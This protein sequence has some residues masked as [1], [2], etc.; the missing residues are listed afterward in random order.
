METEIILTDDDK[1]YASR[2]GLSHNDMRDF[3]SDM[4]L[5]DELERRAVC[6]AE[7]R[8]AEMLLTPQC[9]VYD[10]W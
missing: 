7:Q 6:E 8:R 2:H 1:L 3:I 10:S 9:S 5:A 4:R